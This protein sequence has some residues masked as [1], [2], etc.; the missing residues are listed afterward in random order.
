MGSRAGFGCGPNWRSGRNYDEMV[1]GLSRYVHDAIVA[2]C[3]R[4]GALTA[5]R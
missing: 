2:N 5:E 4:A 1:P 3:E